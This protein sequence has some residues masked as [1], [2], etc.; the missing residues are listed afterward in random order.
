MTTTPR[1][2]LL[3]V[4]PGT[5]E[6]HAWGT[7]G[8]DDDVGSLNRLTPDVVRAAARL[9]RD[10]SVIP[11]S[12]ALDEPRPGIFAP[13]APFTHHVTVRRGGRDDRLD[14]F[15]PQYSSQWDGLAHVRYREFG[16]WGG[17]QETDLDAGRLGIDHV[18]RRGVVGRGVLVDV[19]RFMLGRGQP[20]AMDERLCIS[21]ELI[22]AVLDHQRVALHDGDILVLRTGWLE[23]FLAMDQPSRAAAVSAVSHG[24]LRS[25]GL[26]PA[27]RT[28]AWVW[29]NGV[30]ALAADN[31]AV[32][33]LPVVAST[34]FQHRRLIALLGVP[35]GELW[36]LSVLSQ[37]C[38][39]TG[40]YDFMLV[41]NPLRVPRGVGSTAN[42]CAIM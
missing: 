23:W 1:Y 32:E 25:P 2:D 18:A 14:G 17:C 30:A 35:L 40:R 13:R 26:D 19:R 12:L 4:L 39:G 7:W 11:L 37:V 34:G 16:Y 27:Q 33:A 8:D 20:Y 15:Y 9:V 5:E 29:D 36:D 41:S 10:G 22:E 3:P 31:P 42:V 6:R 21:G 38:A 24:G 28:A